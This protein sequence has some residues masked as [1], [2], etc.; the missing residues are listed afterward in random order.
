MLTPEQTKLL[1]AP[2][3]ADRVKPRKGPNGRTLS[4]V[5]GWDAIERA[6]EV[7]GFDGWCRET[8]VM[9]MQFQPLLITQEGHPEKGKVVAAFMAK[10]RVTLIGKDGRTGAWR[11]GW[12]AATSYGKTA[13]DAIENALKAAETD[14][15]KRALVTFGNQ[16]GLALYDKELKNVAKGAD[17]AALPPPAEQPIDTGFAAQAEPRQTISQRALAAANGR[18]GNR[19]TDAGSLPV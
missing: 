7:F 8:T 17:Q 9:E 6:N 13:G 1:A 14:A 2:L 18:S 16:F 12:G 4:Y 15:T 10:V 11:E 5:E 3:D 19:T